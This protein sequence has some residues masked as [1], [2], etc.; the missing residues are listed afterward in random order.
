MPTF[1]LPVVA[2]SGS[3]V[4]VG[5][6]S[7]RPV[8]Y[9]VGGVSRALLT[10]PADSD[11]SDPNVVLVVEAVGAGGLFV[12]FYPAALDPA[13]SR[14][15]LAAR[16][17]AS[18]ARD[19]RAVLPSAP[20]RGNLGV[21][22][23]LSVSLTSGPAKVYKL[24]VRAA[25]GTTFAVPLTI[26]ARE[27]V[28]LVAP[29]GAP[30]SP[31]L[32]AAAG[33]PPYVELAVTL[34]GGTVTGVPYTPAELEPLTVRATSRQVEGRI[35]PTPAVLRGTVAVRSPTVTPTEI[36]RDFDGS[37]TSQYV[38]VATVRAPVVART[39]AVLIEYDGAGISQEILG[40][41]A[42]APASVSL[43]Q[44]PIAPATKRGTLTLRQA[45]T[46]R[47]PLAIPV[48]VVSLTSSA[49]APAAAGGSATDTVLQVGVLHLAAAYRAGRPAVGAPPALPNQARGA[50]EILTP[51]VRQVSRETVLA[52]PVT[53]T[54]SARTP[55]SLGVPGPVLLPATLRAGLAPRAPALSANR[56]LAPALV[57]ATSHA[58][59]AGVTPSPLVRVPG[60]LHATIASRAASLAADSISRAP[61]APVRAT[62]AVRAPSRTGYQ[63]ATSSGATVG[64]R[65]PAISFGNRTL[66]P[67][68]I[69]LAS[70]LVLPDTETNLR[71]LRPAVVRLA[72]A[73]ETP[74]VARDAI[75]VSP[76]VARASSSCRGGGPVRATGALRASLQ[77]DLATRVDWT[78]RG[79][80]PVTVKVQ[81]NATGLELVIDL[82]DSAKASGVADLTGA[83]L[84]VY[85]RRPSGLVLRR[86]AAALGHPEAGRVIYTTAAGDLVEFGTYGIQARATWPSGRD[87]WSSSNVLVA[88]EN[89]GPEATRLELAGPRRLSARLLAPV[90]VAFA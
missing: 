32:N 34:A 68:T 37:G 49:P 9:D 31:V 85:L 16:A 53:V 21:R 10:E 52:A 63:P 12:D 5:L 60:A 33:L 87:L 70:S 55:A 6:E 11:A 26:I 2:A 48:A 13:R 41:R 22:A 56:T 15:T 65:A 72:P 78:P 59:T 19:A 51:A 81:A 3:T 29:D 47:E 18:V 45:L 61:A 46:R 86:T 28:T 4:G 50:V 76:A 20:V 66:T 43:G 90:S 36:D 71:Y 40:V 23:P 80:G 7:D 39:G 35:Q 17:P 75:A 1:V 30:G 73:L 88:G 58:L 69:G 27:L 79:V 57:S 67:G 24:G 25:D 14:G 42:L 74:E 8:A 77:A 64:L 89:V 44:P 84:E 62:P 38:L 82:A 83:T 54:S